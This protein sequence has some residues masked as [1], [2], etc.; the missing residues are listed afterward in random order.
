MSAMHVKVISF[1]ILKDWLGSEAALI[2]LEEGATIADLMRKLVADPRHGSRRELQLAG[3]AVGVNA[4]YATATRVLRD[5]D[6]V[7]LLPPVSG[8]APQTKEISSL[9]LQEMILGAVADDYENFNIIFAEVSKW[10][11][12][13]DW[14][15]VDI[16]RV[17]RD[18]KES[19]FLGTCRHSNTRRTQIDIYRSKGNYLRSRIF[20]FTSRSRGSAD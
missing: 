8:G 19:I 12:N 20:G 14:A 11:K 2:E 18:L 1:G 15:T 13:S 6:E 16:D 9:K 3:I 17:E 4:E 10:I 7:A 5:G